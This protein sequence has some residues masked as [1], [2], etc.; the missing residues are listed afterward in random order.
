MAKVYVARCLVKKDGKS[1]KK[2]SVVKDLTDK[3]IK[4]GLAEHWLEAV[5][6][7]DDGNDEESKES[8]GEKAGKPNQDDSLQKMTVAEL[9]DVAGS[10]GL[11]ADNSMSAKVLRKMIREARQ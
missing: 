4:Q 7:D 9:M 2:G 3:E 6:S 5:G 11:Q 10:L 8:G 1:Y